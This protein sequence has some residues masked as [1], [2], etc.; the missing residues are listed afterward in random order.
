MAVPQRKK[1][2]AKRNS[3][4]A[5]HDKTTLP[6]VNICMNC[7]ADHLSHRACPECG[8]YRGRVAVQVQDAYEEEIGD[9]AAL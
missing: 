1:S 9:E 2:K 8:W 7:G 5:Q 4:R 6:S 3:R